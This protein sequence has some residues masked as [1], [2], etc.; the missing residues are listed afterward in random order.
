V[1]VLFDWLGWVSEH[2]VK[3][4]SVGVEDMDAGALNAHYPCDVIS[5]GESPDAEGPHHL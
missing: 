1:D 2:V 5:G 3:L 4:D